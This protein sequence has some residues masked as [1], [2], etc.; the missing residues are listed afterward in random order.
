MIWVLNLRSVRELDKPVEKKGTR[1]QKKKG[2]KG[3]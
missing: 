3:R 1:D 2:E